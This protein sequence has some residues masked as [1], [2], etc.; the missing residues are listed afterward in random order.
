MSLQISD[1]STRHLD[2]QIPAPFDDS[3]SAQIISTSHERSFSVF[4]RSTDRGKVVVDRNGES[5]GDDVDEQRT[6]GWN[7][8]SAECS[9]EKPGEELDR[10]IGIFSFHYVD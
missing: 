3:T 4:P 7:D 2:L 9:T 1:G 6:E 5:K 8:R 10:D